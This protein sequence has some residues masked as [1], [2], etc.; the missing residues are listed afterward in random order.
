MKLS[1]MDC[2]FGEL[3]LCDAFSFSPPTPTIE[4]SELSKFSDSGTAGERLRT[5]DLADD[6]EVHLC[7]L[8]HA[9]VKCHA[10]RIAQ[11]VISEA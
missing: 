3:D 1:H 6:C 2:L 4:S 5:R 9:H 7:I 11:T 8:P 10:L